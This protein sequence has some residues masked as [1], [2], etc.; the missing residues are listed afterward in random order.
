MCKALCLK[1]LTL[2]CGRPQ[3]TLHFRWKFTHPLS[4][5]SDNP[6][7]FLLPSL[8]NKRAYLPGRG[9]ATVMKVVSQ[10]KTY[11]LHSR[12]ADPCDF[13]GC[14]KLDCIIGGS[15]R[16][17]SHSPPTKNKIKWVKLQPLLPTVLAPLLFL[18]FCTFQVT[19]R[20]CSPVSPYWCHTL[21]FFHLYYDRLIWKTQ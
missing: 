16:L 15:G 20:V 2:C 4:L 17:C 12:C 7:T 9:D 6:S 11:P 18:W 3:V 8:K 14:E 13:S 1:A 21:F 10:G 19:L 5:F